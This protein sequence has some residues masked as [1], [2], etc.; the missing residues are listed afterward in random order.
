MA[1]IISIVNDPSSPSSNGDHFSITTHCETSD[2]VLPPLILCLASDIIA[3]LA[4]LLRLIDAIQKNGG[5][6]CTSQFYV[7][8]SSEQLLLQTHIINAALTSTANDE[9]VRLC[10]GALAQGASLLQ[11]TFQPILLSGA[12]LSFLGKGRRLKADYKACL[13]RMGLSTEGTVETLRK[14]IDSEIRRLQDS[15]PPGYEERRKELGQ[16]SRVVVL[17]KEIER[18]LALPIPGYWD[19]PECVSILLPGTEA[20]P[21]DEQIFATYKNLQDTDK[22]DG[23]LLRRNTLI[24][25]L[26]NAFRKRVVSVNGASL[27]VNDSKI[28]STQFM[29]ICKE[30]HIRKLFFM[31]QVRLYLSLLFLTNSDPLYS[32]V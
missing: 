4:E 11:T 29:D 20:C 19:L 17:K 28:L 23:L 16:L 2:I 32:I 22:L 18:Q 15:T 30:T 9:D 24:F 27:L 8:S 6:P 25:C 1:I 21:A 7:W 31:Q 26:L 12:L 5:I 13:E 14:R 3:E 10:I